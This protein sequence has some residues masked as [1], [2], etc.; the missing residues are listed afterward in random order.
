MSTLISFGKLKNVD[1]KLETNK[2]INVF[3]VFVI[4]SDFPQAIRVQSESIHI[5]KNR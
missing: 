1:F 3:V 4:L 2:Q 5:D